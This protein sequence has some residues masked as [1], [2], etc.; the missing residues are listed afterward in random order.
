MA[1][2]GEAEGRQLISTLR[3]MAGDS[4]LASVLG[5]EA[6]V[7]LHRVEYTRASDAGAMRHA[8]SA[9]HRAAA[10]KADYSQGANLLTTLDEE[11]SSLPPGAEGEIAG[12]IPVEGTSRPTTPLAESA[13]TAKEE[14]RP[15]SGSRARLLYLLEE[16]MTLASPPPRV[17]SRKGCMPSGTTI[18]VC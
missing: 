13:G 3:D 8:L 9:A 1:A 16:V 12:A 10:D 11:S 7:A 2:L 5:H 17:L 6:A 18:G 14:R 15:P 4:P